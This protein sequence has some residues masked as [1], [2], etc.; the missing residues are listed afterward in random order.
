MLLS[1]H[2][3]RLAVQTTLHFIHYASQQGLVLQFSP[4]TFSCS[5]NIRCCTYEVNRF[6]DSGILLLIHV[7][8]NID[9]GKLKSTHLSFIMF[10]NEGIT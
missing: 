8:V 5:M 7:K 1:Y 9:D 4:V 3:L 2:S 6:R 10:I